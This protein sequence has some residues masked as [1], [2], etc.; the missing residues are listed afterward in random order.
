[1]VWALSRPAIRPHNAVAEI[2]RSQ[3]LLTQ[4]QIEIQVPSRN[5]MNCV[6][7]RDRMKYRA[8]LNCLQGRHSRFR[9]PANTV[10]AQE[11]S[12]Q[13]TVGEVVHVTVNAV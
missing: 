11:A 1:M 9:S 10:R 2:V 3:D 5:A 6:L 8:G 7:S 13:H 12:N 4:S